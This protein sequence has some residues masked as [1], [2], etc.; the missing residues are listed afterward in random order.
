M[1]PK[2]PVRSCVKE[3]E[4]MCVSGDNKAKGWFLTYPQCPC[5]REDCLADLKDGLMEKRKLSIEEYIICKEEHENGDP[6]LHA[7]IKLDKRIRFSPTLF[8]IIYEGKTYHG[9]YEVAKSWNAVKEYVKKDGNYIS[10]I[11][12]EAAE[13]KQSKKL[14]VKELEMDPLDLLEQGV[15]SAFQLT[16]FVKNQ[17]MYRLLK[18]K[19]KAESEI[20]L[21]LEKKRHEWIYGESNTGKTYRI[22]KQ[23]KENPGD[24]FQIPLNNDWI[25]YQNE[26]HLYIDEFKGQLTIQELNRICDGGA[27][28]NT[29]GGSLQLRNDVVVHICSNFNIKE[30]YK[31]TEEVLLESLYNRFME[32]LMVKSEDEKGQI[33]YEVIE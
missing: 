16:N 23:I 13:K 25:G 28:V 10:N 2:T 4:K 9:H 32:K 24:W 18:N 7:F 1:D 20:D 22:K 17:N 3:P 5:P 14:G 12:P 30:C 15:I 26:K 33:K 21:E 11:N 8:D 27:K 6:H 31:K 19:R 29:K